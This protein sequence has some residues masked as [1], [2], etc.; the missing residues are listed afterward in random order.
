MAYST[1]CAPATATAEHICAIVIDSLSIGHLET[2]SAHHDHWRSND[3]RIS[4]YPS[5][6][7]ARIIQ[8]YEQAEQRAV[9]HSYRLD[10]VIL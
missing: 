3:D 4:T 9:S 7:W 2:E 1:H 8:A 5:S 6:I 10:L